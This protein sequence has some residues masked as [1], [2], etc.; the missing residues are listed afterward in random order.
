MH[1][2]DR[3]RANAPDPVADIIRAAGPRPMPPEAHYEQVFAATHAAW[4]RQLR[5]RWQRRW[6]AAAASVAGLLVTG[7]IIQ[8]SGTGGQ[9]PVAAIAL[10]RGT[11]EVSIDDGASWR[12]LDE[13]ENLVAGTRVRTN[14]ESMASLALNGGGSIRLANQSQMQL[15]P[16]RFE[17]IEGTLYF[18][19]DGRAPDASI[20]IATTFGVVEDIGTQ[21][22][23]AT[24]RN[25]FRV[26]VRTGRVSITRAGDDSEI[27][28]D[29]GAEIELAASGAAI[30]RALAADDETWTWVEALAIP[31]RSDSILNYLNWIAR[32]TG[33]QLVWNSRLAQSRAGSE[34]L[35]A[36]LAG[37]TPREVLNVIAA[38]TNFRFTDPGDGTLVI[39]RTENP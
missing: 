29:G 10:A 15:G 27:T 34:K 30:E 20:E 36:D 32:E 11:L 3:S 5:R 24:A 2:S 1:E 21:F 12:S 39:Q 18:D 8:L 28:A 22:E 25:L 7:A 16:S 31:P 6:L 35:V 14:D 13:T 9:D 38:T 17:L 37:Y 26:R 33:K 23:V 4:Q 19:S